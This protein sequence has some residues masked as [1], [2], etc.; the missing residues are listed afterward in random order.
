MLCGALGAFAM[1]VWTGN[2]WL[3]ALAGAAAG[4]L[5]ALIHAYLVIH[6][7]SNQLA[8]GLSVMFLGM[9][10]TAFFGRSFV[11]K[12]I[13]G[14]NVIPIPYLSKI[15]FLGSVFFNHDPLT[16]ISYLLAPLL[17]LFL[18][19]TRWGVILRATGEKDEVVFAYGVSPVLVRYIAVFTGGF[20]AGIGGAQLSIAFTHTWVENMTQGRGIVAVAL[21]IFSSWKPFR[22]VI[23]AYL[24]GGFQELQIALQENGTAISPYLLFMTPYVLTLVALFIIE[25]RQRSTI[26]EALSKVFGH[27]GD[28]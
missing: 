15:P 16:Y 5:I 25:R 21:V 28:G 20:F 14:F 12:S 24:F 10:V 17:W 13:V 11:N 19:H 18:F 4:G 9:G 23:G 3:G 1:T 8:T 2:P 7:K 26:P 27:A 22:A 6:R